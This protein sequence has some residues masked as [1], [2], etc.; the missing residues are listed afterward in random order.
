[1]IQIA[2]NAVDARIL[3]A[4]REALLEV[5]R[6]LSYQVAGSE[7]MPA[8]NSGNWDGR[9]SFFSYSKGHFPAG[10]VHLVVRALKAA[11][12]EVQLLAKPLPE[13]LGPERPEVD[14]FGYV[15]RYDYQPATVD[16]LVQH[17]KIVAQVAT[18]GGKS[19]ICRMAYRRIG[20][21]TLFLTT[22]GVLM[23]QMRDAVVEMGEEVAVLGDGEWGLPYTK[24]DGTPGRRLTKFCVGMSQTLALRLEIKT[25]EGE[26]LSLTNRRAAEVERE[27]AK[28]RAELQKRKVLP[29]LI[30]PEVAKLTTRLTAAYPTPAA[31][32]ARLTKKVERHEFLR[33]ATVK[34]LERFELVIAEEAHELSGNGFYTVMAACK[35]AHYRLAL[36]AT[37]FMKDDEEAN[38]RLQATCGGVAIRVSEELLIERGILARPYFKFLKL[39]VEHK[40]KKL[41]RSTAWQTAYA[42]G[43][44]NDPYRN[45]ILC[46]EVLRAMRYGLNSLMLVQHKAHGALLL[47]MLRRAG[48]RVEYIDGDSDQATRKSVLDRLGAGELDVVVGST[49]LDVGVD[50][51]SIGMIVLAGAG[52][53][54]VNTRQRI[55]RGLREKKNGLPNC[56]FVVDV[57]DEHNN[58]LKSHA[59]ERQNIIKT[60]P[61]F[62]EGIVRDFDYPALGFKRVDRPAPV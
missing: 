9:T 19:R 40:P 30:G 59:A 17:G 57:Y 58:H 61:G 55:G 43:I 12:F 2:Y 20:R 14:S 54:E 53:A 60:T 44:V 1:M 51:P 33:L 56:A 25:V 28:L 10:F 11:G 39:P 48:V 5:N 27:V 21:N 38:M 24:P 47:E 49:I 50:V 62:A 13:P 34:F 42:E 41:Y 45:K 23:Y 22:R 7:H 29:H 36:T 8:F 4:P 15:D 3:N 16:K 32:R 31:D 6:V 52:K 18:G 46:V 35:N 37:P 26:M